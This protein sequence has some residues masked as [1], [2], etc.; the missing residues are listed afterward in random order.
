VQGLCGSD[1]VQAVEIT[2]VCLSLRHVMLI[3]CAVIS[4][5]RWRGLAVVTGVAGVL[6]EHWVHQ[7]TK[8]LAMY[9]SEK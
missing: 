8:A 4:L 9:P 3:L 6:T 7:G 1:P 2:S 5:P